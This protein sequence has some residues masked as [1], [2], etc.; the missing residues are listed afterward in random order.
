MSFAEWRQLSWGD[1]LVVLQELW[2]RAFPLPCF[3][4]PLDGQTRP[5]YGNY[6][7][8]EDATGKTW[9]THDTIPGRVPGHTT[10]VRR[11]GRWVADYRECDALYAERESAK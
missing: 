8:V 6:L 11:R 2:G 10:Y 9:P 5:K 3:G 4:G 7:L 1:R